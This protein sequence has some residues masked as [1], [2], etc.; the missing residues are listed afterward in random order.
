[1][2]K[3]NNIM[4]DN[5][6]KNNLFDGDELLKSGSSIS[7]VDIVSMREQYLERYSKSKGWDKTKLTT[8]QLLEIVETQGYKTPGLIKS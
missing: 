8:E 7:S 1:M 2:S 3:K 6:I 5:L 4:S